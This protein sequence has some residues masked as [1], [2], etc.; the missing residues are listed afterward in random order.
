VEEV[1]LATSTLEEDSILEDHTLNGRVKF[2]RGDADDVIKRYLGACD[3]YNVDVIVRVTADCPVVSPEIAGILL[4]EHLES[5]ADYTAPREYAVGSNSEIYNTAALRRVIELLGS[6]DYS[7][8]MTWYM[9]NNDEI[10]EVNIVDLPADLVREYRLTLDYPEDLEMFERLY[11]ELA[12]QNMSPEL[13]NVFG[14]LDHNPQ[15]P[16][17]N[18]HL[19]L[20]YRS[21]Q[22]LIDKLEEVTKIPSS[23]R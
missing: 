18:G 16:A 7:E 15:I 19:T 20:K 1:V 6:A 3:E 9:R 17:L 2:W 23:E 10:F 14:I 8:Y 11:A 4:R 12:E 21:D 22:A 5:G 13:R